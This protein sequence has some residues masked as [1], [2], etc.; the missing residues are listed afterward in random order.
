MIPAGYMYKKVAQ[1][2]TWLDGSAQVI[3]IHSVSCCCS[4]QFTDYINHWKHNGYWFFDS[5]D[6][7][8]EIARAE[9]LDFEPM[10]LFYYEFFETQFK[11]AGDAG[12]RFEPSSG[13]V[14]VVAPPTR[15]LG[16]LDVVTFYAGNDPECSPLSCNGLAKETKVN[17]HCLFDAFNEAMTAFRGGLF[18]H[19]EAGPFRIMAVYTCDSV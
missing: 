12:S 10:T 9:S 13:A 5:P 19:S 17:Q 7:M 15:R 3:D 1:R 6:P 18:E 2:P 16:G 4:K 8:P 14:S 11:D